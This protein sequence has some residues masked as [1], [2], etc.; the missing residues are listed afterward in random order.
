[1]RGPHVV[2]PRAQP[3][4]PHTAGAHRVAVALLERTLGERRPGCAEYAA[5]AGA[6]V[7][8][9]LRRTRR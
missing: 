2:H 8:I 5:R 6:F 1:M 7:S 9:T 3:M 4:K